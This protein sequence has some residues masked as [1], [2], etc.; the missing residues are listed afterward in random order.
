M[1]V[2]IGKHS[3]NRAGRTDGRRQGQGKQRQPQHHFAAGD[4]GHEKDQN[5]SG[6]G[7][8]VFFVS[9][10][11][12]QFS[13]GDCTCE[14]SRHALHGNTDGIILLQE[15]LMDPIRTKPQPWLAQAK[16]VPLL[17]LLGTMP[18]RLV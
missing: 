17:A 13:S 11:N 16:R 14:K 5:A 15:R 2:F 6:S 18:L 3:R 4:N 12:L 10:S 1:T 9:S 7:L 8:F